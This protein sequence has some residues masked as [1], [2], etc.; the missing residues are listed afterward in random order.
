M[1]ML[2][3]ITRTSE[4]ILR[5][6]PGDLREAGLALGA[7][8]WRNVE[9]VVLPAARTGLVTASILGIARVV[10]ETAP[11]ILTAF[12][13]STV[14]AN[15]FRAPQA[16]LPLFVWSLLRVPNSRQVDRA[17]TGALVLVL[18]VLALFAVARVVSA[19][20]R[21]RRP[22]AGARP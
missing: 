5:T 2:P 10:G 4:E 16:D 13:A 21:R 1:L 20:G 3:T 15:P 17:W 6:V 7:P 19:G 11:M 9:R 12:G 22:R 18:L 8:Q 14:N